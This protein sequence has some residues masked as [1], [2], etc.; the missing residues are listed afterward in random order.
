MTC[1]WSI[2]TERCG[3]YRHIAEQLMSCLHQW[4]WRCHVWFLPH[5]FALL[6]G[7]VLLQGHYI[8]NGL[9]GHQINTWEREES[10]PSLPGHNSSSVQR[11]TLEMIRAAGRSR[12]KSVKI[13]G[14]PNPVDK[15]PFQDPPHS[16]CFI[17]LT[18]S[19]SS[20]RQ[21]SHLV[22]QYHLPLQL[23]WCDSPRNWSQGP[24]N[25]L[26]YEI[27]IFYIMLRI[28][29]RGDLM[30]SSWGGGGTRPLPRGRR[31]FWTAGW[32]QLP[33]KTGFL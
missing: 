27:Y 18:L 26:K 11:E 19:F 17:T 12:W 7:N 15:D 4:N 13:S 24:K 21:L 22:V 31:L 33:N 3:Y 8:G 1:Q 6:C 28:L 23:R 9:D 20:I 25:T 29:S 5:L 30:I 10:S 2:N 16:C 32:Q 14:R